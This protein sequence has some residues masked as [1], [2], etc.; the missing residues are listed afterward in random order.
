MRFPMET[1]RLILRPFEDRDVKAFAEYRSDPGVARYQSWEAPYPEDKAARFINSIR[2]QSPGIPGLW[3]QVA[4][5]HKQDG[6]LIGDVAFQILEED[7]RQAEIGFTLAR[8]YQGQGFGSEAVGALLHYLFHEYNLHR[9]R[10]NCDP[11]NA[12]SGRL[13]Q[14]IGMRH[15][16]RFI[17]SLWFKGRWSS[18]DWYAILRQEWQDLLNQ[19]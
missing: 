11:E 2:S 5:Q 9:V 14:R 3:Y 8:A 16:G 17:E 12:A 7:S 10:A 18:E 19:K 1:L 15:E 4:V 6:S 13:L